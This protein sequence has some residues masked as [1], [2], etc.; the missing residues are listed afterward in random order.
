MKIKDIN[1]EEIKIA[2]QKTFSTSYI[3][4]DTTDL[5]LQ[6]VEDGAYTADFLDN[7]FYVST[8]YAYEDI[9]VNG[10]KTRYKIHIYTIELLQDAYCVNYTWDQ[11][12]Y[13]V[14][15]M[16]NEIQF[17]EYSKFLSFVRERIKLV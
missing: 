9:L 17:M 2:A 5:F 6:N 10:N 12:Y 16:D 8:Q 4:V 15:E 1:E 7:E 3:K 13:A 14:Y 11:K